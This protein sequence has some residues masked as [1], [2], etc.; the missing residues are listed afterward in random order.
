MP[1]VNMKDMLGH[2]H[3][4]RY[5]VAAFEVCSLDFLSGYLRAAEYS[6][7]PII[8][9]IPAQPRSQVGL[10]P[11]LAAVEQLADQAQIPVALTLDH[12]TD[13]DAI[14]RG[15]R[16][17]C[18]GVM[19]DGS[20]LN[21]SHNIKLTRE[22][23]ARA[24]SCGIP[25]EAE[26]GCVPGANE[27]SAPEL[28]TVGEAKAFVERTGVDFLAVSIGTVHGRLKGRPRVDTTRLRQINDALSIPLVIHGGS[29]LG[30]TQIQRLVAN[31]AAKIN[32][33][34]AL[35]EVA[36]HALLTGAGSYTERVQP[37]SEAV[38]K[39]AGNYIRLCGAAG[40]AA[41]VIA[42]CRPS[43]PAEHLILYNLSPTAA[44]RADEIMRQGRQ[45][46]TT[47]PGVR[48]VFAGRSLKEQDRFQLCWLVSFV[49]P[50]AVMSCY[51]HPDHL[52]FASRHFRPVVE[53]QIGAD[54]LELC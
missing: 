4:H 7:A 14:E 5:A 37:V 46:L 34:T 20:D 52:A 31:G 9:N 51:N 50:E 10:E 35:D 2:A 24:H 13:L 45:M 41:E 32:F 23:V 28:T 39:E 43:Q 26:L 54:Y 1:L 47:I 40:R 25:V 8:L 19:I 3:L 49:T 15:I 30:E 33:F 6:R 12:A 22:V 27:E 36:G 42:Q 11:M 18:N 21:I 44:Y 48:R 16:Y 29:G 53:D 17:G 38:Q